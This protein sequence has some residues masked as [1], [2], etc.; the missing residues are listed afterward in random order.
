MN[1]EVMGS[2]RVPNPEPPP[3]PHTPHASITGDVLL[4]GYSNGGPRT[5]SVL[6]DYLIRSANP[7]SLIT[8][9]T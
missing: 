6:R 3:T 9:S 4:Q 8:D 2:G 1:E 5:G 7:Y